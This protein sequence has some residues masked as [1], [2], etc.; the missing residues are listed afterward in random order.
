MY[1]L[2]LYCLIFLL[3]CA[4]LL[5]F[6]NFLPFDFL[7]L[8]SSTL[9]LI[10]VSLLTNTIFSKVLKVPTN[11]ESLFITALILA[12]IIE[13][14]KD[15]SAY[16]FLFWAAFSANVS[17][18]II[19]INRKHIFNPAAFGV[20][21]AAMV[22]SDLT[23][24]WIG[25]FVMLP[26]VVLTGVLIVKKL[27]RWDLVL[28][29]FTI[30]FVSMLTLGRP[31]FEASI[32]FFAFVM[33]TEPQTSPPT[34]KLRILYGGLVGLLLTPQLYL[35]NLYITY[36]IALLLGNIFSYLVSPKGKFILKLKEK[37]R[38]APDIY[39][40]VFQTDHKIHFNAG[41]YMEWTLPYTKLDSRGNRRYFTLSSS[42]TEDNLQIGIKFYPN[43]SIFKQTLT[44]LKIGGRIMAG[45]LSGDFTLPN[46]QKKKL[47]S[48]G[49]A[50]K[51]CF[52]AGGI[53]IT[54]FRSMI[55][56][57]LD[58]NEKRDIVL[59]YS[60]KLVSEIVYKEIF[61]KAEKKLGIK[62][63]YALTDSN[64][65]PNN[66][67]GKMGYIDEQM[68]KQEAADYKE[69]TFYLSGPPSM[70]DSFK[71]VLK[72]MGV[73]NIKTDYFPGYA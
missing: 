38:I 39:N 53:G 12:L 25:T 14:T 55:K 56:Y 17:K 19:A 35:G 71:N 40:F 18:Y 24:W 29:F 33:L 15:I 61:D 47:V 8:A 45:Q 30:S 46:D 44:S 59:F 52:I 16:Q 41:Q 37:M 51:L 60:N 36:E 68:I 13:P 9:F 70:V 48:S 67:Q 10:T 31:I 49:E 66:W 69:R 22:S 62:I 63:I 42:P 34:R 7:S 23:S 73:S 21:L 28:S 6:F 65:I 5:A 72:N 32:L 11:F 4:G 58:I 43:P 64:N 50:T 54:P 3:F 27:R 26:A 1:R 2:V 20:F 57:L